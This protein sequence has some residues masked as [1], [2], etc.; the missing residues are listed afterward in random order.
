[1]ATPKI[2]KKGEVLFKE[3]EKI[4]NILFL[5]KGNVQCFLPRKRNLELFN[6][7]TGQI[8]GEQAFISNANYPFSAVCTSEVT[9]L[10]IPV[11]FTRQQIESQQSLK[12]IIKSLSE[13]LKNSLAEI[14]T[15]KL[16][17]DST[18]CPDDQISKAF[19][20]LYHTVKHKGEESA[21]GSY[22]IGWLQLKQYA[23]R[24]FLESPKRIEQTLLLLVKLKL[25]KI[26]SKSQDHSDSSDETQIISFKNIEVIENFF[27]YF[28]YYY[29]KAMKPDLLKVEDTCLLDIKHLLI[30]AEGMTTDRYGLVTLDLT[31]TIERFKNEFGIALTNDH[32]TRLE[33]KGVFAKRTVHGDGTSVL[34]FELSQYKNIFVIWKILKEIEKWNDK[35][36]VDMSE[37]ELAPPKPKSTSTTA[38]SL[39]CKKCQSEIKE[40]QK[41]CGECGLK[42]VA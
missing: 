18:P 23:Q 33:Q 5:Q 30:C 2:L 3:G 13:R 16:E 14:K 12:V 36:F 37:P 21:P 7:G 6:L 31:A 1:M 9:L 20:A 11:D 42:L 10:E 22:E 39:K 4:Q 40:G 34:Q 8:L 38:G 25:A 29:F 35:G 19:G 24:V 26:E 28:Q 27:E 15:M 17:K 41:F 32:F